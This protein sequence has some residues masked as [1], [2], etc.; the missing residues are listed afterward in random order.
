M[1][2]TINRDELLK[3]VRNIINESM[4][5]T[6]SADDVLNQFDIHGY[7]T[8]LIET[9]HKNPELMNMLVRYDDMLNKGVKDFTVF[10]Q[11]GNE[12]AR[13]SAGNRIIKEIISE[14]NETLQ[15]YG[16]ELMG[17]ILIE[18]IE[19]YTAKQ[20]IG[21][22]FT[23]YIM[24]KCSDTLNDFIDSLDLLYEFNEPLA[25]KLNLLITRDVDMSDHFI[26]TDYVDD[27]AYEEL[28]RRIQE[29]KD[30]KLAEDIYEK[31]EQ[32]ITAKLAEQE[33]SLKEEQSKL[34]LEYIANNQGLNL[35]EHLES[36]R[37]SD[38]ATN[39]R[40]M[41]VVNAYSEAVKMGA[42]EERLYE[43]LI[44]NISKYSYLLPVEKAIKSINEKA[45]ER[46]E[47]IKLTQLLEAMKDDQ[48]S[49]IYVN[50]IQEAVARYV[51][52]PTP[53]N[54]VQLRAALVPHISD[55]Y[56]S[57]IFNVLYA[58]NTRSAELSEQA[59]NIKDQINMIKENV[60]ISNI[61]T[62]VQYI[63]ENEC[64][65][66][67]NGQ[68][69]IKKNNSIVLLEDKYV[70]QLDERFVEL[71]HLVNDPHVEINE[72]YIEVYG[73]NNMYAKVYEGYVD[74]L[75][76]RE[77]RES[78]R[79]LRTMCMKHDNWDTNF[80]IMCSCL[81]ENFNN[82]AKVDWAKHVTLNENHNISADLF[83]LGNNIFIATHNE[84]L[85]QHVFYRN[86]NPIFCKNKLNEHMGIKVSSLFSDLLPSQD[87]IILKLNE[88]KNSY[89][90][91]IEQYEDIIDQ[92]KD[93]L[94]KASDENKKE[95]EDS[96]KDAEAKLDDIKSE[97]KEWQ[98]QTDELTGED[99]DDEVET[100]DNADE[101][102]D[103]TVITEPS[104]EPADDDEVENNYDE[105]TTPIE[106]AS[107]E[108]ADS[109]VSDEE[110]DNFLDM[111]DESEEDDTEVETDTEDVLT[112][113]D[114]EES[115]EETDVVVDGAES[116]DEDVLTDFAED[117]ESEDEDIEDQEEFAEVLPKEGTEDTPE[118]IVTDDTLS[119]EDVFDGEVDDTEEDF[120]MEETEVED[121]TY[122]GHEAT[123]AFGGNV[124][125]PIDVPTTPEVPENAPKIE[126]EE[127]TV[128]PDFAYKIANVMFDENLKNGE[129]S[130]S[131]SVIAIVPMVNAE[132]NSYV[133]TKTV[134]FYLDNENKIILDN[135][136]MTGDLY[137][138]IITSIQ[139]HPSF[140]TVIE[141]GIEAENVE[142]EKSAPAILP[143]ETTDTEDDWEA[144]YLRD[145]NDEDRGEY[146]IT[147]F[148]EDN[149]EAEDDNWDYAND[150]LK[151][152]ENDDVEDT[153]ETEVSDEPA[154]STD[155]LDDESEEDETEDVIIPT[156][157]SGDTEIELPASNVDDTIIPESV[158][159]K[160]AKKH[161]KESIKI[162]AVYKK[163]G[164][165]CFFVNEATTTASKKTKSV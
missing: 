113:V 64:V 17:Y 162:H 24:N 2:T 77:S 7:I 160:K 158:Q 70:D 116:D 50:L 14:M 146:D 57:E 68:Y 156:Y 121:D 65:F 62:P 99:A 34:C 26:H 82:I 39:E 81:H 74:V 31:V 110:F 80:Y 32:H 141:K 67:V 93:T 136:A 131:G 139:E 124:N 92:L 95:I 107:D 36:I 69:Y 165:E 119:D 143:T 155:F 78:L 130:K 41:Q 35:F 133:E 126:G 61:Y 40:L 134:K 157:K 66:N 106:Q 53:N 46:K 45:N 63:K 12:L 5:Q 16:M 44:Q 56:V 147:I 154:L 58:D 87:K 94:A 90:E 23:N 9:G 33:A 97:Y 79:D 49:F 123:D 104:N 86:V 98:K 19:D 1:V 55:P 28:N 91:S 164:K 3:D 72:N 114:T 37:N 83:K 29:E 75:G 112:G 4:Q 8:R 159:P 89:E 10:E 6:V 51:N 122:D 150:L 25:T 132:G 21:D 120:D 15:D 111:D 108:T 52:D 59:F 102:D 88:T 30:R 117:E 137:N 140:N 118:D 142:V 128:T 129:I 125:N 100:S 115:E 161:L 153:T 22:A 54:R 149:E 152:S 13:F 47:Q 135:E 127:E 105:L 151:K 11:F 144:E 48:Y 27:S 103:E 20:T 138:A 42:Y 43:T 76:K 109:E 163:N 18:G 145:G 38:A 60:S 84:S 96:I 73:N 101:T 148:D 71:C 85:A